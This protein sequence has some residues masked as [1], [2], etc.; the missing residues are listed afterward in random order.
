LAKGKN[1]DAGITFLK[2]FG[3]YVLMEPRLEAK[4]SGAGQIAGCQGADVCCFDA[5]TCK[6]LIKNEIFEI[7][8]NCSFQRME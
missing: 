8:A 4:C 5:Q 7:F 3:I 6:L 1:A 2:A